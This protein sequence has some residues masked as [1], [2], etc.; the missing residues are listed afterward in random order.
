M[1]D[2]ERPAIAL[3]RIPGPRLAGHSFCTRFDFARAP[4]WL[5]RFGEFDQFRKRRLQ[6]VDGPLQAGFTSSTQVGPISYVTALFSD[7]FE[8]RLQ[9]EDHLVGPFLFGLFLLGFGR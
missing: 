3:P 7:L 2:R 6:L 9:E 5:W 4:A 8:D 1:A